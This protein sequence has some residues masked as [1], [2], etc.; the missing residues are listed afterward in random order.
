MSGKQAC[1]SDEKTAI[2]P[3][4]AG[5]RYGA[6]PVQALSSLHGSEGKQIG[7]GVHSRN[8]QPQVCCIVLRQRRQNN[9]RTGGAIRDWEHFGLGPTQGPG[10]KK[11]AEKLGVVNRYFLKRR[12]G[13]GGM[14]W[15]P[16]PI[17]APMVLDEYL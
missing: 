12:G 15:A 14:A 11:L 8:Q 4:G 3:E 5:H 7:L 13:G 16:L 10:S 1:L 2:L 9:L 6:G 17:P